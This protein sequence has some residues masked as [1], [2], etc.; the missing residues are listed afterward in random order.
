VC[1]VRGL[2]PDLQDWL[3]SCFVLGI[4]VQRRNG[5]FDNPSGSH[6]TAKFFLIQWKMQNMVCSLSVH[7][8][9]KAQA[10]L[11]DSVSAALGWKS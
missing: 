9:G 6:Q 4:Q 1:W 8:G 2:R 7:F 5:C 10:D 11:T 3:S